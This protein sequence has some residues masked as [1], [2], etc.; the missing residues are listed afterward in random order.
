[1]RWQSEGGDITTAPGSNMD[2]THDYRN[3]TKD[4]ATANIDPNG[5]QQYFTSQDLIFFSFCKT[6]V[7][8]QILRHHCVWHRHKR[9]ND[10]KL[11]ENFINKLNRMKIRTFKHI[12]LRE[13]KAEAEAKR[14]WSLV[15]TTELS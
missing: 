11:F 3:R 14:I 12:R 15:R 8:E 1:M 7:M 6:F 10:A 5:C 13:K 9:L 4:N 2:F